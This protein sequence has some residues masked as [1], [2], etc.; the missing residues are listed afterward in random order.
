MLRPILLSLVGALVVALGATEAGARKKGLP[1]S[2]QRL[3]YCASKL[4]DCITSENRDCID[5]YQHP[6]HIGSCMQDAARVCEGRFGTGS[7]CH[8]RPR[9]TIPIAAPE[10]GGAPEAPPRPR[11]SG[12]PPRLPAGG[13]VEVR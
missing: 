5:T 2:D 9:T 1:N 4:A 3:A 11:P 7:D 8:T 13:T 12:R 6:D 10:A